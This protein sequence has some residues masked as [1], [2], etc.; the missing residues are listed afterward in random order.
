M[1]RSPD[2]P[3]LSDAR[4]L[5]ADP[6]IR[7]WT[8]GRTSLAILLPL[9]ATWSCGSEGSPRPG[10]GTTTVDAAADSTA[11]ADVAGLADAAGDA[12]AGR[13]P[14]TTDANCDDG[15]PCTLGDRCL[16][17]ACVPGLPVCEC[18]KD[19]DCASEDLCAAKRYCDVASFPHRCRVLAGSATVC[20]S[21]FDTAR[22][23]AVCA[24]SSGKCA[25]QPVASGTPCQDGDLC[26]AE[27]ACNGGA[28]VGIKTGACVCD[29]DADCAAFDDGNI[30][31]GPLYCDKSTVFGS[32]KVNPA[33]AVVCSTA[34]DGPCLKTACGAPGGT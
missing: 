27:D 31:T 11:G 34:G 19:A 20:D 4:G 29:D 22:A 17:G 10:A 9:V 7:R 32:C 25:P 30:C 1:R 6:L 24:P 21:S 18:V 13:G 26:T 3:A 28:C 5:P 8:K 14:C 16:A 12:A 23:R 2:A 33:T 15:D